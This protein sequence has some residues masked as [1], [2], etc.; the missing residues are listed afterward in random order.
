[1]AHGATPPS[2]NQ[3]KCPLTKFSGQNQ[4]SVSLGGANMHL[5][6]QAQPSPM[7][8]SCRCCENT[9]QPDLDPPAAVHAS[10]TLH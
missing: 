2:T 5:V 3:S 6:L 7:T 9:T 10:H 1:M 8:P 4:V